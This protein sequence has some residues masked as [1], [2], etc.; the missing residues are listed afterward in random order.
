MGCSCVALGGGLTNR[1]RLCRR[2]CAILLAR[3]V[4]VTLSLL[5]A[6]G[7]VSGAHTS[8]KKENRDNTTGENANRTQI[9]DSNMTNTARVFARLTLSV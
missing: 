5:G 2:S 6:G 7:C 1:F 3:V 4:F 8:S 9:G